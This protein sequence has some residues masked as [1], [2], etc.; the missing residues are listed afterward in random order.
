MLHL[1]LEK[2]LERL[3]HDSISS[4]LPTN[5]VFDY[6]LKG[7]YMDFKSELL[8]IKKGNNKEIENR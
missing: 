8:N 7:E 5:K 4:D 6:D 1:V 3:Q 2:Q